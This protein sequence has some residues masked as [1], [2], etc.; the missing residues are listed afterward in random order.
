LF[1]KVERS[2]LHFACF[3]LI[4]AEMGIVTHLLGSIEV[5]ELSLELSQLRHCYPLVEVR[6]YLKGRS[7]V[8]HCGFVVLTSWTRRTELSE[9]IN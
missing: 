8:V 1:V 5:N 3:W 9:G 2:D 7:L 4:D 6:D